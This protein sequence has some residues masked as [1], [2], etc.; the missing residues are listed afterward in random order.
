MLKM[1]AFIHTNV[2]FCFLK[3]WYQ[4]SFSLP[5]IGSHCS[6]SC[7]YIATHMAT[8]S[9]LQRGCQYMANTFSTIFQQISGTKMC[10]EEILPS[11]LGVR[12]KLPVFKVF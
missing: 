8:S 12:S 5:D 4:L 2:T 3:L 6:I 11:F 7:G 9:V 1:S 10:T